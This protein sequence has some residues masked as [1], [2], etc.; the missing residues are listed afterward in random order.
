MKGPGEPA[1]TYEDYEDAFGDGCD[2][3]NDRIWGTREGNLNLN[4][5]IDCLI[6]ESYSGK[7]NCFIMQIWWF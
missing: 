4:P 1:W 7:C 6:I 5:R 3:S 2:L